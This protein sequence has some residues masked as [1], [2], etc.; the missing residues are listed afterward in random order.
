MACPVLISPAC[1][2]AGKIVGAVAR[3]FEATGR[4]TFNDLQSASAGTL[5]T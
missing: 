1:V 5:F 3:F 2:V 4:S